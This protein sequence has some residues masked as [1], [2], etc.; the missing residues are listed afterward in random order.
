MVAQIAE[1]NLTPKAR[2]QVQLLLKGESMSDVA[3]WADEVKNGGEYSNT[4]S[5]HFVDIPDGQDYSNSEHNH[6]GDV[7]TA[8]TEMVATLKSPRAST[9]EKT[10]ALKFLIH[11]VG[12]IHQPLH[13]GRPSDRGGNNTLVTVAGKRTNLH[14]VWDTYLVMQT[15]MTYQEYAN[16]LDHVKAFFMAPYDIAEFPFSQV[17]AEDLSIRPSVYDFGG[18]S[19]ITKAYSQKQLKTINNQLLSG[20]KRLANVLNQIFR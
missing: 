7:V 19:E 3:T 17:I 13:V 4:K 11:F 12:D 16:S 9:L 6:D 10:D 5:W 18:S 15:P 8:I 2:A 20:G 14:A 1:N